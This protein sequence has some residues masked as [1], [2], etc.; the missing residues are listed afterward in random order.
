MTSAAPTNF[1]STREIKVAVQG[2]ETEVLDG[3]DIDWRRCTNS[4]HINCPYP[5]HGGADDWRWDARKAKAFCTCNSG[6]ADAILDV[7]MKTEGLDL[8]GAKIRAAEIINRPD[9]IKTKGGSGKSGQRTDAVSL[10]NPPAGAGDADL[11]KAYLAHRLGIAPADVLIPSTSC[12]GWKAAS[13]WE[14]PTKGTGKPVEVGQF[15]CAVFATVAADG[16]MHAHR[17]FVAPG[18]AGKADLGTGANGKPRDPKKSAKTPVNGVSTA[19]RSVMWGSAEKASHIIVTEGIETGAAVAHALRREV[20]AG[21]VAV[22]AAIS[23]SG[24]MAWQPWPA[25]RRVTIAADRDEARKPSRPEPTK[26]GE[27]AAREFGMRRHDE[28]SAIEVRIALPGALGTATDWLDVLRADGIDAVRAGVEAAVRF[29]PTAAELQDRAEKA[30]REAELERVAAMYPLP[31]LDRVSLSYRH[32]KAGK[33][34]LHQAVK[35]GKGDNAELVDVPIASPFG[36]VA[37]L[38]IVDAK[39]SYGLRLVVQDMGGRPRTIDLDRGSHLGPQ[40]GVEARKMFLTNGV[41]FQE[42]GDMVAVSALKAA[43]PDREIII[44]KA[45]GWH[46]TGDA[47]VPFFVAPDGSVMGLPEGSE[48]ELSATAKLAP[49]VARKGT[50]QGWKA[51]TAAALAVRDCPH[52]AV[53]VFAGFAGTLISLVED[54]S[55]GV[56]FSGL[57]SSG[58][59]TAQK[60][61]VSPWS[62]PIIGKGSLMQSAR[63]TANGVEAM[64]AKGN[65]TVLSLDELAH[66]SGKE[67]TKIV[68]L[69]AGGAGKGRMNADAELRASY[70]WKTFGILSAETSLEEKIRSDGGEWT[71]GQAVRIPDIDVTGLN[72]RVSVDVISKIDEVRNHYGH[73]GHAFVEGIISNRLHLKPDLLRKKIGDLALQIAASGGEKEGADSA[74]KRAAYPFA[75]L[76]TAGQLAKDFGLIPA[77][78]NV[79][80]TIAWAWGRFKKSSDAVALDPEAQVIANLQRWIAERW[81]SSIHNL[82]SIDYDKGS[83]KDA[84]GWFDDDTIYL[85]DMRL[86]EAAGVSLKETEIARALNARGLLTKRKDAEHLSVSFV[87][88]AGRMKAYALSREQFGRG[89]D[90]QSPLRAV[91]GGLV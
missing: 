13:Y 72:R 4:N 24:M 85:S 55:C 27:R 73:A 11:P 76:M 53:G 40:G 70:E 42:N 37:R 81:G 17:I 1:V 47:E 32:T 65:G 82:V 28:N 69:V 91:A 56:N 59:T 54:N 5:A 50:L 80:G 46:T 36:V 62:R 33:V 87:P 2:R 8:E 86:V 31:G 41:R 7:C 88:R 16:G 77:E 3:L 25:T 20:E 23:A 79:T 68:Y 63:A 58:K 48:I 6:H 39:E 35:V 75:V 26:A 34:W 78:T 22:A 60:L 83:S 14:A 45:P 84:V 15:P 61:A 10:L 90:A 30:G 12:V 18:G 67:L 51:A 64:A 21:E 74:L 43:D 9:L 44:V 38:K 89:S 57:S 52:W 29:M 49:A 66:V 71:A 19:G